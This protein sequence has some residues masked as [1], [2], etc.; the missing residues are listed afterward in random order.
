MK[1][2]YREPR[3]WL[4]LASPFIT[5]LL[6]FLILSAFIPKRS[7]DIDP[8]LRKFLTLLVS[9]MF[10]FFV[11]LGF[12]LCSG[13][14]II[15]PVLDK[16]LKLRNLMHFVGMKSLAYYFGSFVSD[17]ILFSIPTIGF[18]G[19]LFPLGVTYFIMDG[20]WAV[21]LATMIAFG[22]A[23]I[24]LTYL[25]SFIFTNH[26]NAFKQ[27]GIIYLLGGSIVPNILGGIFTGASGTQNF[28]YFRYAMLINPFTNFSDSMNYN[29]I[30]NF[31]KD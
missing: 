3:M 19:L 29:M 15:Q 20:A 22:V 5:I 18:I 26:N 21:L 12:S 27:I 7:D 28:K 14:Y 6:S 13:L 25:F 17:M 8:D 2:F 10:S 24:N 9:S 1:Q 11:L 4:L 30:E 23:L 16:E 31:I